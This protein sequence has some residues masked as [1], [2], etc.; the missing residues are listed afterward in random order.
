MRKRTRSADEE[1]NE[2]RW[3]LRKKALLH[4]MWWGMH[5]RGV[6]WL[7][8]VMIIMFQGIEKEFDKAGDEEGKDAV[9]RA[10]SSLCDAFNKLT[11]LKRQ[12]VGLCAGGCGKLHVMEEMPRG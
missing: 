8:S 1:F 2:L 3:K 12:R 7:I 4:E 9:D 5:T 6:C 10:A 11:E